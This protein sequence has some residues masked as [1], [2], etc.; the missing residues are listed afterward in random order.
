MQR[1]SPPRG[2]E[3][4]TRRTLV[5]LAALGLALSISCG[6]GVSRD[7][8]RETGT[9]GAAGIAQGGNAE[10][11]AGE[12]GSAGSAAL[13]AIAG[14]GG[15]GN[16]LIGN[17]EGGSGA[18]ADMAG[19]SG[20][21]RFEI[22]GGRGGSGAGASGGGYSGAAGASG[23]GTSGSGGCSADTPFAAPQRVGGLAT[24][25]SRLRFGAGETTG[26]YA[27]NRSS[28]HYDV[29]MAVRATPDASFGIHTV[30]LS[31][32]DWDFSP[33]VSSDGSTIYFERKVGDYWW[34]YQG[35][36]DAAETKFASVVPVPGLGLDTSGPFLTRDGNTLYFQTLVAGGRATIAT[37]KKQSQSFSNVTLLQFPELEPQYFPVVSADELSL[38]FAVPNGANL[39][40][41]TDIWRATRP[42]KQAKFS[43]AMKL[44]ELSTADNE[45]PSFLSDD[46]CRLYFDRNTSEPFDWAASNQAVWVAQ[47]QPAK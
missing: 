12:S 6:R 10:V 41:E 3:P 46:G 15:E 28:L 20:M 37:A 47:R 19:A 11:A 33:A 29:L 9:G 14:E 18:A 22:A 17:A 21:N 25:A 30:V 13:L 43:A 24:G 42:S 26:Y 39:N 32:N 16:S 1:N 36:W 44:T 23:G 38:Y 4:L 8:I 34:I 31:T 40:Y 5:G 45:V 2:P 35:T 7:P 27:R